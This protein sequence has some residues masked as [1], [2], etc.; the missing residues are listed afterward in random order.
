MRQLGKMMVLPK[1]VAEA[2]GGRTSNGAAKK[3]SGIRCG[4]QKRFAPFSQRRR[5][6]RAVAVFA[7]GFAAIGFAECMQDHAC[8]V[9][10]SMQADADAVTYLLAGEAPS[11]LGDVGDDAEELVFRLFEGN[12]GRLGVVWNQVPGGFSEEVVDPRCLGAT[13]IVS[14]RGVVAFVC[15]GSVATVQDEVQE[16]LEDNGWVAVR[17][18]SDSPG[19]TFVKNEGTYR[20]AY[21]TCSEISG[22]VTVSVSVMGADDV[23]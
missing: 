12:A 9:A 4:K 2:T 18:D 1:Q 22:T 23:V 17:I 15:G 7:F 20:W 8:V 14:S 21:V 5:F 3:T 19:I 16:S 13:D 11:K 10:G 6:V